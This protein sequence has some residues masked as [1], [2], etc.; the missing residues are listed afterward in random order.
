MLTLIQTLLF[1][2]SIVK[3]VI[4]AHFIMS[5]LINFQVLNIRQPLVQQIWYGLQR[6]LA[7]LYDPLRRIL[8]NMGGL[9]LSPI[10][11]L[12]VIYMLER[13]LINNAYMFY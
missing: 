12:V 10:L 7:P 5:W 11:V 13:L 6:L 9:D 8:P 3:F 4:F 1:I 2:L